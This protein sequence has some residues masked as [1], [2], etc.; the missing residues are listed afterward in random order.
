MDIQTDKWRGR[1]VNRKEGW[2]DRQKS[3]QKFERW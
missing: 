3:V 2:T 1:Q